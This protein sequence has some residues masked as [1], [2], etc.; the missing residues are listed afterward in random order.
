MIIAPE[1]SETKRK[2]GLVGESKR[3]YIDILDKSIQSCCGSDD[4]E[5]AGDGVGDETS[6]LVIGHDEKIQRK[7]SIKRAFRS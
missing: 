2:G 7:L 1:A 6:D 4:S 5:P 3:I